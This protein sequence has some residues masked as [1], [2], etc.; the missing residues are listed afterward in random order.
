M[1]S[2]GFDPAMTDSPEVLLRL[3]RGRGRLLGLPQPHHRRVGTLHAAMPGLVQR[4][5]EATDDQP[6]RQL[7]V[8]EAHLGLRWMDVHVDLVGGHVEEQRHYRVPVARQH[9]GIGATHRA[10][11]QPVLHGAPVDE[12]I[13]VI[14]DTAVEGGDARHPAQHVILTLEIDADAVGGEVA[15]GQRRNAFGPRH[16]LLHAQYAAPVMLDREAEIGPR[17]RQPLHHVEAGGIFRPGR[18]QELAPRGHLLEQPFDPN[19]GTGRKR[20]RPLGCQRAIVHRARPALGAAHSTLD[21]Q[22]R[23]ARDRGQRLAAKTQRRDRLDRVVGQF[24]GRVA[25]QRQ[26]HFGAIHAASVIGHFDQVDAA[27]RE[28]DGDPGR[29][30]ID[31]IFHKFLERAG[32][33]FH[34]F[35]GGN[36]VDKMLW[37][38]AY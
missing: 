13:L 6:A 4:A 29:P 15:V 28:A 10:V 9:L 25:L 38:T 35:A 26:R 21:R 36:S 19:P 14:G 12:Q 23:D 20:S 30:G 32:R 8:A 34:H 7:R 17:H 16:P 24:R 33:A 2:Q 18:S 22:P 1:T 5:P 27:S 3:R 11:E 31:R 37:E